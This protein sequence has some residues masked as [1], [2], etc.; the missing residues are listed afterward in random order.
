MSLRLILK[1]QG[2]ILCLTALSGSQ[3]ALE[4][5]TGYYVSSPHSLSGS[6]GTDGRKEAMAI[7][8]PIFEIPIYSKDR[9]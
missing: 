6:A 4:K 7:V 1:Q 2:K 3:L 8:L 9:P 5:E